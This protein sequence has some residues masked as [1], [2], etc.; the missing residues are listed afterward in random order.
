MSIVDLS[1]RRD[2]K[3]AATGEQNFL[4]CR[5]AQ[6]GSNTFAVITVHDA[7]G[8]FIA[9]LVC[10]GCGGQIDVNAGRPTER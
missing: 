2:V 1:A 10:C 6:E 9:M 7:A 3:R 4:G 5:C 8:P